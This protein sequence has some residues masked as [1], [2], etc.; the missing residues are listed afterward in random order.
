MRSTLGSLAAT[1]LSAVVMLGPGQPS[2]L[3][4]DDAGASSSPE[5]ALLTPGWQQAQSSDGST[6]S[7]QD[8]VATDEGFVAL[9]WRQGSTRRGDDVI[10]PTWRS[11][12]GATW[13][14]AEPIQLADGAR[15]SRL[16]ALDDE[17][18]AVGMDGTHLVVWRSS[19]DGAWRRL[20]DR[21]SFAANPP[22]TG[23]R[24]GASV[25]D[26]ATGHGRIVVSGDYW[27]LV[28]DPQ[29]ESVLWTSTDGRRWRRSYETLPPPDN[30]IHGLAITPSGFIG[31]VATNRPTDCANGSP[32][33]LVMSSSNGRSWR[34][35]SRR[36]FG[37]SVRAIT[38]DAGS[39]RYSALA[40]AADVDGSFA[41]V[42]ASD[43][44]RTWSEV[45][46]PLTTWEG[47]PWS[48]SASGIDSAAGGVVVVG[49]ADWE[50]D[51]DGSTVWVSVSTDGVT[52][53]SSVD[54]P[55]GDGVRE[56]IESWAMDESRLV[57]DAGVGVWYADLVDLGGDA[58]DTFGID[59]PVQEMST[60]LEVEWAFGLLKRALDGKL[61]DE[62]A[63]A[64]DRARM[65]EILDEL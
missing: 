30:G 60:H 24:F 9:G 59:P 55:H 37:C 20:R 15:V 52:W 32:S 63:S 56:G 39:G 61:P 7:F 8:I 17:L 53:Q 2:V 13:H 3:A 27:T 45:Y 50:G 21:R 25:I 29:V 48:P 22:G 62:D 57:V 36:A 49:D 18:Y 33:S 10:A 64:R 47:Q 44:L 46:R 65:E 19:K 58:F 12:D 11:D 5:A 16:T 42:L 54:W 38:Y 31:L 40:E 35:A 26:V 6:L 43:D 51:R 1:A 34:R 4:A 14:P 23:R 28:A 41:V